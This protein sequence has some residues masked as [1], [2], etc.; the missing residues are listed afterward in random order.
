MSWGFRKSIRV[1]P[2]IRINLSR[3]G[4]STSIGGKG[5]TYN[6]RGRVTASIPGT[7]IRFTKNLG[8]ARMSRATASVVS[9]SG[10][11]DANVTAQLSKRELVAHDFARKVH[12]RT[13]AALVNYFFSHGVYVLEDD[14]SEAVTLEDHQTF[15]ESISDE[16]E[17]TTSAIRL[18]ADI[19]TIS[20]AEKE[21]AMHA[22]YEI[23][24][25]CTEHQGEH[26]QL[27]D[28]A[29]ALQGAVSSWPSR[30]GLA[31]P[32]IVA[33][34]G[35]TVAYASNVGVGIGV[36]ALALAYGWLTV[37]SYQRKRA[38]AIASIDSANQRFD[39][40]LTAEVTPRPSLAS[41]K[42]FVT[43]QAAIFAG[44]AAVA[45][46][47]AV[48]VRFSDQA[49]TGTGDVGSNAPGSSVST[50][51]PTRAVQLGNGKANLSWLI[52]KY[53]SDVV[54]DRRFKAA[55]RNVSHV[56]WKAVRERLVVTNGRAIESKDGFLVGEGC[57]EHACG[58]QK[59]TFAINE[60]T[61]KGDL[62]VM[63]TSSSSNSPV[64]QTYQWQGMPIAQTPLADWK[65]RSQRDAG[66]TAAS[67]ASLPAQA[68]TASFAPS[69]DCRKARSD[70]EHLVC[71][72]AELAADDV[73]LAA[74]YAKAKAAASDK[75][76]FKK[77]TLAQWNYREQTC[78][79]R[80][81]L[82]RWYED[83]K[84]ALSEIV[85]TGSVGE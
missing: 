55:F 43:S 76:E 26:T 29:L 3:S 24:R 72:D 40:L 2:G 58:S 35:V 9:A 21:R 7:G 67:S 61:G 70:A 71:G 12:S 66:A 42:D 81:C 45:M 47:A 74:L 36:T 18:A 23:E 17:T 15:L 39:S 8:G 46:L 63:K 27:K 51:P 10:R 37:R 32:L 82:V 11:L 84:A 22:L 85:L 53:P 68:T 62:V 14:L 19:G 33:L 83:Q 65:R 52:G 56:E 59:A 25:Q 20:L 54:D 78:H 64:F 44:V 80:V 77:R 34:C 30:P 49:N 79:D 28:A 41:S 16:F 31:G 75:T 5:F 6:T 60:S 57:M 69:F 73:E 38:A 4:V 13:S 1:A 50:S 48:V